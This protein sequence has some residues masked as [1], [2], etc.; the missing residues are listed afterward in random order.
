MIQK[1]SKSDFVGSSIESISQ[2][3]KAKA[4]QAELDYLKTREVLRKKYS[5]GHSQAGKATGLGPVIAGSSPA[6]PI[7]QGE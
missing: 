5:V 6:A 1:L 3:T 4:R 7:S 2:E